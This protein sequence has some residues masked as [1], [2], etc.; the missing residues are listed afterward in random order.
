[1]HWPVICRGT[2][3]VPA[4]P[5]QDYGMYFCQNQNARGIPAISGS[6]SYAL[7][8]DLLRSGG[9]PRN[10]PAGSQHVILPKLKRQWHIRQKWIYK[11]ALVRDLLRSGGCP[12]NTPNWLAACSFAKR[13]TPVAY[14]P[15]AVL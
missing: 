7:A 14:P 9:C 11:Y 10:V 2:E 3:A 5:R 15:K 6:T 4:M 12:R 8:R 1:M 13:K